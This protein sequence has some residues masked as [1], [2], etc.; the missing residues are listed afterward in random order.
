M[1]NPKTNLTAR[2]SWKSS[3]EIQYIFRTKSQR[4][5]RSLPVLYAER[6]SSRDSTRNRSVHCIVRILSGINFHVSLAVKFVFGF[7]IHSMSVRT[8]YWSCNDL[9]SQDNTNPVWN[10]KESQ[11]SLASNTYMWNDRHKKK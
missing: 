4:W 10:N 1:E 9:C 11:K 2:E 7:S 3:Q 6:N 8:S 5:V